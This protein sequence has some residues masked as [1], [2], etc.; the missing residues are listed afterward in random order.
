MLIFCSCSCCS[1]RTLRMRCVSERYFRWWV[2]DRKVAR[3]PASGCRALLPC[4]MAHTRRHA[5][6]ASF[7]RATAARTAKS[8]PALPSTQPTRLRPQRRTSRQTAPK[9][10]MGSECRRPRGS[11]KVAGDNTKANSQR[12]AAKFG[13]NRCVHTTPHGATLFLLKVTWSFLS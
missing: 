2:R 12:T 13:R 6:A 8:F 10:Q 4:S 1:R 3:E 7:A 5:R 11:R 9:K